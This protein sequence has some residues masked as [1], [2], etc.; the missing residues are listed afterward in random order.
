MK[1]LV[2]LVV[3]LS[4][5]GILL[6]DAPGQARPA[7]T[8]FTMEIFYESPESGDLD[9]IDPVT[10]T[11]SKYGEWQSYDLKFDRRVEVGEGRYA[12][13]KDTM[14]LGI[15][16]QRGTDCFKYEMEYWYGQDDIPGHDYLSQCLR[17][18]LARG[19]SGSVEFMKA[20]SRIMGFGIRCK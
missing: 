19:T 7:P 16:Q 4:W 5:T 12:T 18:E 8:L 15:Y 10:V 17:G 3:A 9:F 11:Y 2:L 13:G 14:K 20:S 1:H 6:A